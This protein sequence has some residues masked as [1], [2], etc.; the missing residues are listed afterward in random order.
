[1]NSFFCVVLAVLCNFDCVF[2]LDALPNYQLS[3]DLHAN[4][5]TFGLR[6]IVDD[7]IYGTYQVIGSGIHGVSTK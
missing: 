6:K 1:M 5:R 4:S 2:S 7:W 3:S